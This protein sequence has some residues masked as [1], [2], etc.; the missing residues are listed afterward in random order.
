MRIDLQNNYETFIKESRQDS[1][2]QKWSKQ[3][4]ISIDY[5]ETHPYFQDVAFLLEFKQEFQ[6]EYKTSRLHSCNFM[7]YWRN[8]YILKKPLKPRAFVRL[9]AIALN[10]LKIRQRHQEQRN[11]IKS[12]RQQ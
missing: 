2:I 10:C 8:T 12:L 4:G 3:K 7:Q 9:E 5:L 11:Q 6:N 1:A